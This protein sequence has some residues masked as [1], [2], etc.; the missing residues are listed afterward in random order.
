[1]ADTELTVEAAGR[2]YP[3]TIDED[4]RF[5]AMLG[6]HGSITDES[7]AGLQRRA[8]RIKTK[9]SLDFTELDGNDVR[10]GSVTGFHATNGNL[11][12]KWANGQTEQRPGWSGNS[13]VF[14]RLSGEEAEQLRRLVDERNR[15]VQALN[16]FTM[17]RKLASLKQA[18]LDEQARVAGA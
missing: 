11:L 1:M 5:R 13:T 8:R 15:A 12:I 17:P 18:A 14:N 16:G 2:T 6:D 9:F 4:G 3:V 10:D 7:F